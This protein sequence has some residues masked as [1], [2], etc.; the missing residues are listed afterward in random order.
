M[1]RKSKILSEL[2]KINASKRIKIRYRLISQNKYSLYLDLCNRNKRER[3]FLKIYL[4]CKASTYE[5][6][7]KMY[8]HGAQRDKS[9]IE[10]NYDGTL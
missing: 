4:S 2:K 7:K 1:E 5:E 8:R 3:K 9:R 6:D 10:I